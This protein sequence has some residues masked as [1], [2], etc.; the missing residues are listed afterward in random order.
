MAIDDQSFYLDEFA[1]VIRGQ[2]VECR[3]F[4]GPHAFQ[5]D[6]I[7]QDVNRAKLILVDYDFRKS[8]AIDGDMVGYIKRTFPSFNGKIVLLS[9]IHDFLEDTDAIKSVFDGV[10]KKKGLKWDHINAYLN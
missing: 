2:N 1:L 6:A 10:L 5:R 9:L 8:T 4:K 7:E 3:Y